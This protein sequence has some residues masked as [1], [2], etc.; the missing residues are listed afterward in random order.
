MRELKA[1]IRVGLR[2]LDLEDTFAQA[3]EAMRFKA[4][5]DTLTGAW[6]RGVILEILD[7][8][9]WR[10]R[11][12]GFSLGVLIADLDHFKS[13]YDTYGHLAKYAVFREVTMKCRRTSGP[14]L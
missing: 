9:V 14:I 8:E 4:T 3:L 11:R 6:N 2:L 5:Y 10:S 12:Q 7:R 1:W 13:V